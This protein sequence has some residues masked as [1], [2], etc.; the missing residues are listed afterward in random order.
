MNSAPE[1][2]VSAPTSEP[3]AAA[4]RP[5]RSGSSPSSSRADP[6]P[7]HPG[8]ADQDQGE[9]G[10]RQPREPGETLGGRLESMRDH[11]DRRIRRAALEQRSDE[12]GFVAGQRVGQ[13]QQDQGGQRRERTEPDQSRPPQH[14]CRCDDGGDREDDRRPDVGT[15]LA[16]GEDD[17]ARRTGRQEGGG[18]TAGR[19]GCLPRPGSRRRYRP[20]SAPSG[21][22]RVRCRYRRTWLP[23]RDW[24]RS[25][26][27][28]VRAR[29]ATR[30]IAKAAT[31]IAQARARPDHPGDRLRISTAT[32]TGSSPAI[33]DSSAAEGA[34]AAV[35]RSTAGSRMT[36]RQSTDTTGAANRRPAADN[37]PG[38]D[39]KPGNQREQDRRALALS[40]LPV[41]ALE[42]GQ[43][44][45]VDRD[46]R[47]RS[48]VRSSPAGPAGRS[49]RSRSGRDR[50]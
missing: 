24:D 19:A 13:R 46:H 37:Q 26:P 45:V 47:T 14:D 3:A 35:S 34:S 16:R 6:V 29:P 41:A 33:T 11:V 2:L 18:L 21:S 27:S 28:G 44:V 39:Q 9:Q 12:V 40:D 8:K 23:D 48:R 32:A 17:R 31:V 5:A 43:R 36:E 25:R 20:T 4:T 49:A 15:E 10:H 38:R 50:C 30:S 42:L 22:I 7:L 1:S